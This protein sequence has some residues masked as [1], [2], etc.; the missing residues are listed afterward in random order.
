MYACP[1]CGNFLMY[2]QLACG[3]CGA[4][5][6]GDRLNQISAHAMQLE[7]TDPTIA[8]MMWRQ[9][10]DLLPP[11]ARQAHQIRQRV[12]QLEGGIG[13]APVD[14]EAPPPAPRNDTFATALLKTGGS[15]LLSILVYA[16]LF[17]QT[18]GLTYGLLFATG[19]VLLILVHELGHSFAMRYYG[20]SASPPIFIPFMGA[21][22]NLRQQ[23]RNAWEE[24]V[25][26]IGG[27]ALGTIGAVC[28][29]L[30][31]LFTG[32]ELLLLLAWFGYMLNLFNLL[33]VP[34]LD[35]GR[36]TAA[37]SP[38][39]WMPGLLG[40]VWMIFA[41]WH[42]TGRP[43]IL[44][45]LL[46]FFAWPRIVQTLR[47]RR[48]RQA[49]PYYDID[50]RARWTM[51]AWYFGLGLSLIVLFYLTRVALIVAGVAPMI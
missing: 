26:G 43:S 46:L 2:G 32:T 23:P 35:G 39:I 42:A 24:A 37:V 3:R 50:R 44:L 34:P 33:P 16:M 48:T 17:G 14:R 7:Q 25:V 10:L 18:R 28:C 36:I 1:R 49:N 51:G 47:Q 8:A 22:I 45:L 5:V 38:W 9:A 11:D 30:L 41:Q 21:L 12:H 19:F 6:Y 4:L 29:H 27:P 20:L 40:L 31:Y 15:M 13:A